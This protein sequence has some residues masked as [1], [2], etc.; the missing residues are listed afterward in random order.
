MLGRRPVRGLDGFLIRNPRPAD[1]EA[2]QVL[3]AGLVTRFK[4]PPI[5]RCYLSELQALDAGQRWAPAIN[6]DVWRRAQNFVRHVDQNGIRRVR[7]VEP[8]RK[9]DARLQERKLA[10]FLHF[11]ERQPLIK[12]KY[13]T[14]HTLLYIVY[15]CMM[16][17]AGNWT[18]WKIG[19]V[20]L[21]DV[22]KNTPANQV[23]EL[24]YLTRMYVGKH[25]CAN[26]LEDLGLNFTNELI[27]NR[28]FHLVRKSLYYNKLRVLQR[29]YPDSERPYDFLVTLALEER[30]TTFDLLVDNALNGTR[31]PAN[32]VLTRNELIEQIT[33]KLWVLGCF[34][35]L[36]PYYTDAELAQGYD[37]ENLIQAYHEFQVEFEA[38]GVEHRNMLIQAFRHAQQIHPN[39][40]ARRLRLAGL[41]EDAELVEQHYNNGKKR[42]S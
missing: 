40:L 13:G 7:R 36:Y 35:P 32:A 23:R 9:I 37:P 26:A 25:R 6:E 20:A 27:H 22:Q 3:Y 24:P 39:Q 17:D 16:I 2:K 34:D 14:Y 19:H 12:V 33:R 21:T 1:A 30:Q 4:L 15:C 18:I 31:T 42:L 28:L 38:Q 11:K 5:E 10:Y 41:D 29:R 8:A